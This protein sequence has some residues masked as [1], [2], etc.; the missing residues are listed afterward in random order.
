MTGR[1]EIRVREIRRRTQ[2]YR[3]RRENRVLSS[4]AAFSLFL[5]AGIGFLLRGV[6][7]RGISAVAEGYSSVLLRENA[8]EYIVVGV[9]A[10]VAG[11]ALT[12]IC[13]R[14]KKKRSTRMEN[15]EDEEAMK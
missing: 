11:V 2:R 14:C 12:V 4:L 7:A 9:A 5:L 15:A 1:T 10:F 13:L 3:R 6:Q 8:G